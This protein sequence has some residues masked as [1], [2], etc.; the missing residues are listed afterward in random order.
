[1]YLVGELRVA[2]EFDGRKAEISIVGTSGG[3]EV[4]AGWILSVISLPGGVVYA[5]TVVRPESLLED[6]VE[7]DCA[8]VA[9]LVDERVVALLHVEAE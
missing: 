5:A 1:M 8:L 4:H 6:A 9:L 2:C 3:R 7:V